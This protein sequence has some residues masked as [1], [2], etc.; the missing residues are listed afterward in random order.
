M[1]G[2]GAIQIRDIHR[3]GPFVGALRTGEAQ[4]AAGLPRDLIAILFPLIARR[5]RSRDRERYRG[6]HG[7]HL[8]DRM[9]VDRWPQSGRR[10]LPQG[11]IA[12]VQN[13]KP[14][15]LIERDIRGPIEGRDR[16][17]VI[18][19]PAQRQKVQNCRLVGQPCL[20]C[21]RADDT[22]WT[23]A[24]QAVVI[25][26]RHHDTVICRHCHANGLPK[27]RQAS[28][29]IRI[30][31][32]ASRTCKGGDQARQGDLAHGGVQTVR[33][34]QAA[35][36]VNVDARRC[37]EARRGPR[38]VGG[39]RQ[40]S[41]TGEGGDHPSGSDFAD[42]V[43]Q[44]I[45][46][47]Y[48]ARTV[49]R[50]P[51]RLM[52]PR[53]R[54]RA[55]GAAFQAHAA[56]QRMHHSI[57]RDPPHHVIAG[58]RYKKIAQRITDNARRSVKACHR[59]PP[60]RAANDTGHP[61]KNRHHTI[62]RHLADDMVVCVHDVNHSI[63]RHRHALRR[64][65]SRQPPCVIFGPNGRAPCKQTEITSRRDLAH[66]VQSSVQHEYTA[67]AIRAQTARKAQCRRP[68]GRND[69]RGGHPP[70]TAISQ[71]GHP[72]IASRISTHPHGL[73]KARCSARGIDEA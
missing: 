67:T 16:A 59:R 7:D 25:Q 66:G 11:V 71:V 70:H 4:G 8:A 68:E 10:P 49:H 9:G 2:G 55:V 29:A 39:S 34:I 19:I 20:T 57:R 50:Q 56:S 47:K 46:D 14:S 65:E 48:V 45:R 15:G 30:A 52:E 27:A 54:S 18:H 37:V 17:H 23:D 22:R 35:Q 72:H 41:A 31:L 1:A 63:R 28:R 38:S 5:P 42:G 60:R 32:V 69:A 64:A 61:G 24:P 73:M 62:Q 33:H 43:I 26:I 13:I 36:A 51:A 3:I 21:Q 53:R 44:A 12:T 40:C 58:I 6:V